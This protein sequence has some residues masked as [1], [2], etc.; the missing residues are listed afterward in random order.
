[1]TKFR[2]IKNNPWLKIGEE[3]TTNWDSTSFFI[4]NQK[5]SQGCINYFWEIE[6]MKKIERID[7]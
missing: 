7:I 3:F 6:N 2:V 5:L 4:D 1:M